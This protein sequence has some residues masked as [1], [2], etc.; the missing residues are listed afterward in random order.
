MTDTNNLQSRFAASVRRFDDAAA[1]LDQFCKQVKALDDLKLQHSEVS[2]TFIEANIR[3]MS[4]IEA[5]SPVGKL[6]AKV[7]ATL[8]ET[9][10]LAETIF[11]Q[12]DQQV[13]IAVKDN[14]AALS[15]RVE[16]QL[17]H[18]Q[19]EQDKAYKQLQNTITAMRDHL[20]A[21]NKM[22]ELQLND[23]RKERD[24]V[25]K[26]LEEMQTKVKALPLRIRRRFG[27]D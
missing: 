5:L 19:K 7:L 8:Q 15:K 14:I 21:L 24:K 23:S 4:T 16:Q 3:L 20:A 1:A 12:F 22:M 10:T 26:E 9:T 17:D 27:L 13:A 18:S 6:G 11:K 25:R 2:E